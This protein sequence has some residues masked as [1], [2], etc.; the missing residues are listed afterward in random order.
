MDADDRDVIQ[1]NFG[2]PNFLVPGLFESHLQISRGLGQ[3]PRFKPIAEGDL[4]NPMKSILLLA[5]YNLMLGENAHHYKTKNIH[6][7]LF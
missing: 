7:F 3:S 1:G 2:C 5:F 4:K 6:Q